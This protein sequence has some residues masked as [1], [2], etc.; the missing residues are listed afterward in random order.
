M[1]F[2][3]GVEPPTAYILVQKRNSSQFFT[4]TENGVI[5]NAFSGT[6]VDVNSEINPTK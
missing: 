3:D 2:Y 6:V 5:N 4:C 1:D